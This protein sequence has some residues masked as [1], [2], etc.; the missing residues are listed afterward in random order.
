MIQSSAPT[1]IDLA[2]GTLDIWPLYH[3]FGNPPTLNAAI[4]LFAEVQVRQIKGKSI[5]VKSRDLNLQSRFTSIHSIP[6]DH[7]LQLILKLIKFY[8]PK[9]GL[10]VITNC[11]APAGSGIGGSSA[12]A[13]AVNGA[14]NKLTE[15]RYNRRHIIEIAR[16]IETEV[17]RAPGGW[18]DFFS[19]TYGGVQAVQ[20]SMASVDSVPIPIDL[21]DLTQRFVL[22]FTG[23]P[24]Q[25]GINNWNVMK[26]ALD[27][28][29]YVKS[30]LKRIAEVTQ[31]MERELR[32][33]HLESIAHYFDEEWKARKALVPSISTPE[34]DN[35]IAN[36]KKKRCFGSQS[37]RSRRWR[38]PRFL[39]S[40]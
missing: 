10:E 8:H 34:I 23:K 5:T 1:R 15:K 26:K 19:A 13:I 3:F 35:M 33:G 21:K 17:I 18:Q 27:G 6:D 32:K 9:T 14:L 38:V 29:Q 16:N 39:R 40:T 4:D 11:Q 36:A 28:D 37:L 20:P 7:P 12:L 2:G 30:K 22:C 31:E 25:S 24:R